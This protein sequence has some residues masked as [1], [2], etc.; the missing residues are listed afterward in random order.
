MPTARSLILSLLSCLAVAGAPAGAQNLFVNPGFDS[1]LAGWLFFNGVEWSTVD[2]ANAP[3]S[4]SARLTNVAPADNPPALIQCVPVSPGETYEY[5]ARVRIPPGQAHTGDVLVYGYWYPSFPCGPPLADAA[6][7]TA[8]TIGSWVVVD[9]TATAP[10]GA[11]A[12]AVYVSTVK[13]GDGGAFATQVDDAF[14]CAAGTCDDAAAPWITSPEYPGFRFRVTI[15]TNDD[16]IAGRPEASCQPD[17]VCV[18]GALP[19]R[20]EVFLRILG[21]RPNGYLWPTLV[22]FTPSQVDVEI[23]QLATGVVRSYTLPAIP[24]G[25]DELD[26]LQDRTGFRP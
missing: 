24:P 13:H 15:T 2:A 17:T 25:V 22:R 11:G 16:V 12:L 4:G 10:A 7:A 3:A 5:G 9:A 18:S 26:G 20:S 6:G 23:E 14:A 21:P 19:G 1:G 8:S